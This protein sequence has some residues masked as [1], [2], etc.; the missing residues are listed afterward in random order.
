MGADRRWPGLG[1]DRFSGLYLWAAF[2]VVFGIWVPHLFLTMST[3]HSLAS[4]NS[5]LAMIAIAVLIPLAAGAYDLS[6]GAVV[7]LSTIMV[8]SLQSKQHWGMWAAIVAA[9]AVSVAVGAVNGFFVVVLKVN[10]FIATLGMATIL[11]AVQTIVS[12][13]NQPLPPTSHAW[14]QLTQRTV[15][16]FQIIFVYLIVIALVAWWVLDHT[17]IGRYIYAVGGNSEAARLSGVRVDRWTWW[18]LIASSTICGIAGVL[19]GSLSGPSLTFGQ[20]LL[21]PAFAAV[22]LG[23]TQLKPGRFNL[24]GALIAVFVLATGVQGL[25][26]VTGVV[27]LNDMFNGVALLGAVS[28]AVWRQRSSH[29]RRLVGHSRTA[30]AQRASSVDE[31][32]LGDPDKDGAAVGVPSVGIPGGA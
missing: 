25:G 26:Y 4:Q 22:F 32:P 16:G 3:V 27:W 7:N 11:T 20:S 30:D 10:S 14:L 31:D 2:I 24:W 18:A 23:S 28:F 1:L 13:D 17:P 12:G 29:A 21:L 5:V 9:I 6:V 19:Y 15:A 8:T